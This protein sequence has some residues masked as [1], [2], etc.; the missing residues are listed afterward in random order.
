MNNIQ[1]SIRKKV[2]LLGNGINL[3]DYDQSVSWGVLLNELKK[4][5]PSLTNVD[6]QNDFKPFP[7]AFEEMLHRTQGEESLANKAQRLKESINRILKDQLA[8]KPGY[9]AFHK[10]IMKCKVDEILTTNYDYGLENSVIT[11]FNNK[12]HYLANYRK[13]TRHST[14]R[15]YNIPGFEKR[16]W[17]IHGESEDTRKLSAG[18]RY[19]HEESIMI[20]YEHYAQYLGKIQE[21][22]KGKGGIQKPENQ[23]VFSRIKNNS[24]GIFWFDFFF[25]HDIYILGLGLSF[26]EN[27]LWWLL[28]QRANIL[29]GKLLKNPID[30]SNSISFLMP[31]I[32]KDKEVNTNEIVDMVSFDKWFGKRAR[33]LKQKAITDILPAFNVNV[34]PIKAPDYNTFYDIAI[35]DYLS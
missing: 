35:Q 17:H 31:D 26:S 4:Q 29:R 21:N 1:S 22:I 30:I 18:S 16:V 5:L 19:Y 9:N 12:K 2:L 7:L 13:E 24:S 10:K 6:L 11:D 8:G 15:A 3:L 25:T 33:T 23:S 32:V 27:H 14:R 34:I 20:G 28:N